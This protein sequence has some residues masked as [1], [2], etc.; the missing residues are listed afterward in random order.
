MFEEEEENTKKVS[1]LTA[2]FR[3]V[4]SCYSL[5]AP[6]VSVW[7]RE[8]L[9]VKLLRLGYRI[10]RCV[11]SPF[12]SLRW[13]VLLSDSLLVRCEAPNSSLQ[14]SLTSKPVCGKHHVLNWTH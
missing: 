14:Y 6:T 1:S 11:S 5:A 8:D 13:L 9:G 12:A 4:Y 10:R 3:T 7:V 2:I